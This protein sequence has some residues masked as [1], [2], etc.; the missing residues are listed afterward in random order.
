M[1]IA[2]EEF[3]KE[4]PAFS[5]APDADITYYLAAIVQPIQLPLVWKA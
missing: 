1:R 2:S 4:I 5:I 3:L